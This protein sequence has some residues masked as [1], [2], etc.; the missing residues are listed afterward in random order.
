MLHCHPH[1]FL[2]SARFDWRG[3]SPRAEERRLGEGDGVRV[4]SEESAAV[5]GAAVVVKGGGAF[6]SGVEGE[7][8]PRRKPVAP[9]GVSHQRGKPERRGA[10]AER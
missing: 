2:R 6:Q 8:L 7:R 3:D 9:C 1:V 5:G 4:V 10:G